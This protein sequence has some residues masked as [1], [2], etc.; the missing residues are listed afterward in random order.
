MLLA[1]AETGREW[2]GTGYGWLA[3]RRRESALGLYLGDVGDLT[4]RRESPTVANVGVM[5]QL[6]RLA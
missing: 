6:I 1:C 2:W 4:P 3:T 5:R